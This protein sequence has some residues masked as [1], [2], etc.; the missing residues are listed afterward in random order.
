MS[1]QDFWDNW[2]NT[3]TFELSPIEKP[4]MSPFLFHM[5]GEN[6]IHAILKGQGS[7]VS[8]PEKHGWIQSNIP[9]SNTYGNYN[10]PVVCLTESPIFCL[11]FFRFRS[12]RRWKENQ[13][14]GV[15]FSKTS[16]VGKKVR[17]C[18]YAESSLCR[19]I[20]RLG[21]K[22]DQINELAERLETQD[23]KLVADFSSLINSI[24]PLTVSLS[25]T[26][27][28]QGFM[29]EREWRLPSSDG[30]SFHYSDIKVVCCPSEETSTIKEILVDYEQNIQFVNTWIEYN[31]V[32]D[33]L[34]NR[35]RNHQ[36]QS[37]ENATNQQVLNNAKRSVKQMKRTIS[38]LERYMSVTNRFKEHSNEIQENINNIK[39]QILEREVQMKQ[40]EKTNDK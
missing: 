33:Y 10:A 27:R 19:Q 22:I 39:Q 24:Y 16:F 28:Y 9:E 11:D 12:H 34:V 23:R 29:W 32:T 21:H 14:F 3:P 8:L 20:N 6:A 26:N 18:I 2:I 1:D 36:F 4:D 38:E 15:G 7:E 35:E 5:T 13:R 40:L 37:R 25:E 30:L 31:E 17:P